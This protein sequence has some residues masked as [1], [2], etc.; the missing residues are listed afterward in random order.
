M[1]KLRA[2]RV[3]RLLARSGCRSE[4]SE[5]HHDG[6]SLGPEA[7]RRHNRHEPTHGSRM[8]VD[9][10]RTLDAGFHRNDRFPI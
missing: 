5:T 9:G 10:R 7:K 6:T 4:L 3:R 1:R 8:V 2:R